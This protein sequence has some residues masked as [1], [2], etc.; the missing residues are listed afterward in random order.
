MTTT[1]STSLRAEAIAAHIAES[2]RRTA[3]ERAEARAEA[4]A[5]AVRLKAAVLALLGRTVTVKPSL[6]PSVEIE[7]VTF[8]DATGAHGPLLRASF[9]CKCGRRIE[10]MVYRRESLG[11]LLTSAHVCS[12]EVQP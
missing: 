8:W 11:Y 4:G 9:V 12:E 7:G 2:E 6:F 3:E 5:N 10:G 1:N